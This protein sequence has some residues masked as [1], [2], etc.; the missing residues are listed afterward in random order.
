MCAVVAIMDDNERRLYARAN[1]GKWFVYFFS[2]F[3]YA[4]SWAFFRT[5]GNA[6]LLAVDITTHL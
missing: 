6:L 4:K 3:D 2:Y 1:I 5:D